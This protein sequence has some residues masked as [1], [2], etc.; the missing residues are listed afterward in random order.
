MKVTRSAIYEI[1]SGLTRLD[2]IINESHKNGDSETKSFTHFR[3]DSHPAWNFAKNLRLVKEKTNQFDEDRQDFI[4]KHTG[5]SPSI[6]PLPKEATDEQRKAR[7]DLVATIQK[8]WD[9][10]L[11]EEIE[12]P[13]LMFKKDDFN[14]GLKPEQNQIPVSILSQIAPLV[15]DF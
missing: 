1:N 11:K 7:A 9:L 12:V 5:G 13:F 4:R 3:F 14:L 10:F 6:D 8:D 2:G 15:E